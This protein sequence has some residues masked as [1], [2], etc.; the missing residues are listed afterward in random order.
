[1]SS[2][3]VRRAI[4]SSE[5][6]TEHFEQMIFPVMVDWYHSLLSEVVFPH[7][8]Q[9]GEIGVTVPISISYSIFIKVAS[10]VYIAK[11]FFYESIV[12]SMVS[13]L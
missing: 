11:M 6:S 8:P 2:S 10:R 4:V 12:F 3:V 1:M 7:R 13:R 5:K 9:I